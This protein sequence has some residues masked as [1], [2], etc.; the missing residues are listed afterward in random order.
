MHLSINLLQFSS[1]SERPLQKGECFLKYLKKILFK[2]T[3]GTSLQ[4]FGN[5][6]ENQQ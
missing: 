4:V 5:T 6:N 1:E 2:I 3:S